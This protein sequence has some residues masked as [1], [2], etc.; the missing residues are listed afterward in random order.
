MEAPS[1]RGDATPRAPVLTAFLLGTGLAVVIVLAASKGNIHLTAEGDGLIYR[2]VALH[3]DTPPD[4]IDPVVVERGTSLRY[5][6]IGLPGAMWLLAAGQPEAIPYTHA[7]IM[8]ASAGAAAAAVVVLLPGGGMLGLA[9]TYLTPAFS[10]SL[11]GGF[12]EVPAIAA[13]LWAVVFALRRRWWLC[14][15]LLSVAILTKESMLLVLIGLALWVFIWGPLNALGPLAATVIPVGIW[16]VVVR[17]RWGFIPLLDPY[18][19]TSDGHR[20]APF[21][22]LAR[23]LVDPPHA[24]G[25][26]TGLVHTGL[27]VAAIASA[28][29]SLL[30][31]LAAVSTLQ[32]LTAGPFAWAFIG[33]AVRVFLPL[34]LFTLLALVVWRKPDIVAPGVTLARS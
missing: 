20:G 1:S 2:Y 24:H 7:L 17:D 31:F 23:G 4:Q 12:A 26:I 5:G 11:A 13:A 30:G 8:V 33:E 22:A 29:V 28:R 34:Q 25:L 15:A 14:S 9:L 3:L 21:V 6:R 18:L 19:A 16:Y 27:G 32:L 10:L